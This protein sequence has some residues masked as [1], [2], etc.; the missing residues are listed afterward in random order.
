MVAYL[1]LGTALSWSWPSSMTILGLRQFADCAPQGHPAQKRPTLRKSYIR[2]YGD[3]VPARA[4]SL[5]A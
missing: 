2:F 5:P 1:F 4:L 3:L